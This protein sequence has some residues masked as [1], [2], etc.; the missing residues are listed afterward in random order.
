MR[1]RYYAEVATEGDLDEAVIVK[2]FADF[3][4]EMVRN[5]G[6]RGKDHIRSHINAHNKAAAC[7]TWVVLVDLNDTAPCPP[8]LTRQWLPQR[9]PGMKFSVA[10]RAVESWLLADRDNLSSYLAIN[11]VL[12]PQNPERILNPK[13]LMLEL[14]RRSRSR[15]IREGLL[16]PDGSTMKHGPLYISYLSDFVCNYWDFNAAARIAPSLDYLIMKLRTAC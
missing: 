16:P 2:V 12:V 6:K 14:A 4:W 1:P 10:V 5:N 15:R 3:G 9:A 13:P 11:R 8:L 7:A